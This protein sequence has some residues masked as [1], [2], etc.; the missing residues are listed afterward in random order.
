MQVVGK[1]KEA[2]F[3]LLF[4]FQMA[5]C[6]VFVI[7]KWTDG[8]LDAFNAMA[9][10]VFVTAATSFILVEGAAMLSDT[11]RGRLLKIGREEGRA[12]TERLVRAEL[13]QWLDRKAIAEAKDEVFNE[14]M[15]YANAM[16]TQAAR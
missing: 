5:I 16:E 2:W 13:R 6:L 11:L 7:W 14:P 8:P 10:V 9:S 15:P 1:Y 3:G 4:T 12:E